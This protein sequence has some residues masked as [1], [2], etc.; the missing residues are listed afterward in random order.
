[1]KYMSYTIAFIGVLTA[2]CALSFISEYFLSTHIKKPLHSNYQQLTKSD[3]L[4]TGPFGSILRLV[5]D[6]SSLSTLFLSKEI[7][8]LGLNKRPDAPSNQVILKLKSCEE[9]KATE[10]NVPIYLGETDLLSWS[11]CST[12][13]PLYLIVTEASDLH[14]N[15]KA[16]IQRSENHSPQKIEELN[17]PIQHQNGA[18]FFTPSKYDLKWYG[19]DLFLKDHGGNS[20]KKSEGI[21]KV[22]YTSSSKSTSFYT[23][24][25]DRFVWK[26]FSWLP[27]N[28]IH[29]SHHLFLIE[30]TY[31]SSSELKFDLWSPYGTKK[32]SLTLHTLNSQ[33]PPLEKINDSLSFLSIKNPNKLVIKYNKISYS[34]SLND[35]LLISPSGLEKISTEDTLKKYLEGDL[36]YPLLIFDQLKKS[37]GRYTLHA[38]IYNATRTKRFDIKFP[39]IKRGMPTYS[40][41]SKK[42]IQ[43]DLTGNKNDAFNL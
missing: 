2:F 10:M 13:T 16:F 11:F 22:F 15:V 8:F 43:P 32:E 4:E 27:Y 41:F 9:Y 20:Y 40:Y 35:W 18:S 6:E 19:Q 17:I 21:E 1:M 37:Q 3:I 38:H 28:K 14:I 29:D 33:E 5:Q 36:P 23:G 25:N 34:I 39:L 12:K 26:D 42:N 30:C 31:M 24:V 7:C